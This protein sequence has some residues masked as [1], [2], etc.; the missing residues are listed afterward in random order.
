M[1]TKLFLFISTLIITSLVFPQVSE[2][3][4]QEGNATEKPKVTDLQRVK[5]LQNQ[6][7][8]GRMILKNRSIYKRIKIHQINDLWI[9]Y[10]K[11][12][13]THDMMK[14]KINRIEYGKGREKH[15]VVR[16]DENGKVNIHII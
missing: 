2:G 16:F 11:N 1:Q 3:Q 14:D 13:S 5:I 9:V 15:A 8:E 7:G 12:G 6:Y 10:I 4:D